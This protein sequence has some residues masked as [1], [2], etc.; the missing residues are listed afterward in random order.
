[1]L[2][3]VVERSKVRSS[4]GVAPAQWRHWEQNFG[5]SRLVWRNA[6]WQN[7][8]NDACEYDGR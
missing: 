8:H 5:E 2:S 3:N 7:N 1:M 4:I 6:D